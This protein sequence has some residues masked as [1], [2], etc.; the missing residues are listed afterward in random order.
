MVKT[1]REWASAV[2]EGYY[3]R[4][5]YEIKEETFSKKVYALI[6]AMSNARTADI[7]FISEPIRGVEDIDLLPVMILPY[8]SGDDEEEFLALDRAGLAVTD[9]VKDGRI[10]SR[11]QIPILSKSDI[12]GN[13]QNLLGNSTSR[14]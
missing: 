9:L 10:C 11:T 13:G 3:D 6:A 12:W 2:E 1:C 14:S 8:L 5:R 7:S 4:S